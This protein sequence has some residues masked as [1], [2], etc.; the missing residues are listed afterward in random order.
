MK[1]IYNNIIP[2]KGFAA[3]NLF[4]VLFVRKGVVVND[5]ILNH[6]RIHT[7]QMKECLYLFFYLWY[8]VEW[9]IRLVIYRN[10]HKA[11]RNI[12]FE[13]EAYK[14]ERNP[15]YLMFHRGRYYRWTQFLTAT[16]YGK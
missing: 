16:T 3:I 1:I 7:T 12:S 11:Y 4:G 15:Y 2:V 9:L 6:E 8:V 5:T 10:A 14:N 13:Q